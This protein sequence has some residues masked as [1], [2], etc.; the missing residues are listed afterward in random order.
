MKNNWTKKFASE[1][2]YVR[3]PNSVELMIDRSNPTLRRAMQQGW[4]LAFKKTNKQT[5]ERHQLLY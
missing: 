1:F 5:K 4:Q 2:D 3:F